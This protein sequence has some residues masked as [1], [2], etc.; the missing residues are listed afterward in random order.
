[1][2]WTLTHKYMITTRDK[3]KEIGFLEFRYVVWIEMNPF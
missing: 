1:M 3:V 2:Q